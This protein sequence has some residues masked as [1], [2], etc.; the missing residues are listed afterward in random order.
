MKY[1]EMRPGRIFVLSLEPGEIIREEVEKFSIEHG[2]RYAAVSVVGGVDKGSRLVV[3]PKYPI[4]NTIEPLNHVL[5]APSE[6][7]GFGTLFPD[8]SGN[9]VLHMHGTAGR[10]GKSVTGCFRNGM[11]AWFVTEVVIT[12]MTGSGPVRKIDEESGLE[13]MTII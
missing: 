7:T 6:V 13:A 1:A 10:E 12:E 2:I 4:G 11:I 8:A 3:G 5:D 9:P